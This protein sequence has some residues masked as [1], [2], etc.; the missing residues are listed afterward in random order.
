MSDAPAGLDT[1]HF[2]VALRKALT[3]VLQDINDYERV[4]NLAPAPGRSECWDSVARAKAVLAEIDKQR[5]R[6]QLE[7]GKYLANRWGWNDI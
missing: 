4:N 7:H 5:A 6:S 3:D 1:A 2:M